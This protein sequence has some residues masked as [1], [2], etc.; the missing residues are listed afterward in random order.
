MKNFKRLIAVATIVG[1]LGVVGVA[2]ASY[3]TGAT[4][5]AGIVSAL[6]G[7]SVEAVTAER[8]AG[9]TFGTIAQDAG[10]LEEFKTEILEQKKAM[11]DQRVTDGNITQEQADTMVKSME[12]NQATCDATGSAKIGQKSGMGFRQGGVQHSGGGMGMGRGMNTGNSSTQ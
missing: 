4:T 9:K 5:P 8:A 2:S 11:L 6:T 10:M 3:A 12:T 7:K 1:S